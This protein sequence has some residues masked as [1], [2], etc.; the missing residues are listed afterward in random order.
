MLNLSQDEVR[1]LGEGIAIQAK[2]PPYQ[3]WQGW[4]WSSVH[5]SWQILRGMV[6]KGLLDVTYQSRSTTCYLVNDKG[7][8]AHE[9]F[10]NGEDIE[11]ELEAIPSNLFDVVAG[12][13]QTKNLLT[14]AVGAV[15][16]VHILLSGEPASGKSLFLSELARLPNSRLSLGG[17]SSRAGIVD[18]L[19]E[20]QPR[21]FIIDEIDKADQR[22]LDVL[23]SLMENGHISRLKRGM[24]ESITLKTWVFAGANSSRRLSPALLSRFI[25]RNMPTYTQQDFM[26]VSKSVL[27]K[28][29]RIDPK[30]AD[31]IV[32]ALRPRTNNPRDAV[33][34]ARL[35][36]DINQLDDIIETIWG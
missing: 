1:I 5:G 30:W 36:Q 14:M 26:D 18:F 3:G 2:D 20:F 4:E 10:S 17:T 27:T 13:D 32:A 29:E 25:I 12:H 8:A 24:Q 11:D 16:P 9:A 33:K 19:I 7:K 28:R 15:D 31:Q 6:A 23:L 35:I 21:Y 34:V 22:D